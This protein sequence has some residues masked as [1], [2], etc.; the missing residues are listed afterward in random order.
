MLCTY[1]HRVTANTSCQ[2]PHPLNGRITSLKPNSFLSSAL[3]L[4]CLYSLLF[5]PL[6]EVT[7]IPN[8]SAGIH[9]LFTDFL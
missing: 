2:K 6:G 8:P 3:L 1:K 4:T 7:P 5:S 9:S